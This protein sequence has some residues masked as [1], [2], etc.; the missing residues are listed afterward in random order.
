[1]I[2]VADRQQLLRLT[3]LPCASTIFDPSLP[4]YDVSQPIRS[5]R[6]GW[7]LMGKRAITDLGGQKEV[8]IWKQCLAQGYSVRNGVAY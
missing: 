5:A 6:P 4:S 1:M 7:T 2:V 8:V 3:S